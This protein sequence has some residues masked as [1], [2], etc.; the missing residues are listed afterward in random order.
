MYRERFPYKT[1]KRPKRVRRPSITSRVL[2]II[3]EKN[4][5]YQ[6]FLAKEDVSLFNEFKIYRMKL[7]KIEKQ[8]KHSNYF[9]KLDGCFDIKHME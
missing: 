1:L 7:S 8:A 9:M 5:L 4:R 2:N 6:V 3:K